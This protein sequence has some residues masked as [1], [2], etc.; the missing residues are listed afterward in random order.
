VAAGPVI[1][2][3]TA[4]RPGHCVDVIELSVEVVRS[5]VTHSVLLHGVWFFFWIRVARPYIA[6]YEELEIPLRLRIIM[7]LVQAA[8][9][10]S[11]CYLYF[12]INAFCSDT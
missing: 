5:R 6:F 12:P 1:V 10:G 3:T 7:V 8:C 4:Y 2:L 9:R 11:F